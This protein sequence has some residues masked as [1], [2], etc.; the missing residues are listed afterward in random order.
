MRTSKVSV[1]LRRDAG[2]ILKCDAWCDPRCDARERCSSAMLGS[3]SHGSETQDSNSF[4]VRFASLLVIVAHRFRK[5]LINN[6]GLLLAGLLPERLRVES[7]RPDKKCVVTI[8]QNH[9][10]IWLPLPI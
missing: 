3:W 10:I 7:D 4:L 2:A 8:F 6:H 5:L 9:H 1:R